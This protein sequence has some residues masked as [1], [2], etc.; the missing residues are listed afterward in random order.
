MRARARARACSRRSRRR[1]ICRS[2]AFRPTTGPCSACS[3]APTRRSSRRDAPSP[4]RRLGGTG[5]LKVGADFLRRVAPGAEVWISDP[6]WENHRA[7]FEGAGF[8]VNTY[9]YYDA[10]THGLDFAGMIARARAAHPPGRSSCCTRAATTRLASTSPATQWTRMHR[11]RARAR[12]RA[13]PRH[14][15]SGLRRRH[16]RRRRAWCARFAATPGPLFVASSF[17]KSFSLY[18]ERVG[19]AERRGGDRTRRR[20]CCRSSSAS[21]AA[22]YSNPPTHGGQIVATVLHV[23]GAA[24]ALGRGSSAQMRDRI[25]TMRRAARRGGCTTRVPGRD[26]GFILQ[27][28]GMFS[29]SGLTKEQVHASARRVLDLRGRHRTYLRRGAQHSQRRLRR[30]RHCQGRQVTL[31]TP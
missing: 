1:A 17:S 9:P 26:F 12:A 29:Y 23:A 25:K 20:A 3:S 13:D 31:G 24:R 18:G 6:S 11:D 19:R 2:T 27:Q 15:L 21:C 14:C 22:N 30:R 4:C 16:R 28:R 8:T 10:A 7:L 5:A